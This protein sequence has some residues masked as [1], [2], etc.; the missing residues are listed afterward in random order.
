MPLLLLGAAGW[1]GLLLLLTATAGGEA[2]GARSAQIAPNYRSILGDPGMRWKPA[3]QQIAGVSSAAG[4]PPLWPLPQRSSNGS[5]ALRV[6]HDGSAGTFFSLAS[7]QPVATLVAAFYRYSQLTFPHHVNPAAVASGSF[8]GPTLHGLS[9]TVDDPSETVLQ[10]GTDESYSLDVRGDGTNATLHAATVYGAVR[11]LET[12]SQL[13]LFDFEQHA[14]TLPSAPW[15]ISDAPRFVHRGVMI[16][17]SRHFQPLTAVRRLIESMAYVKLN[18]LHWHMSDTQSFP[19]EVKSRP[20]LWK[21]AHSPQERYLQDDIAEVI[22]FARLRAV[23]VMVEFDLPGH[24]GS[25][26]R[27]Y[28]EVCPSPTCTPGRNR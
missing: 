10:L 21:A 11:G 1:L 3:A 26:C 14:Y 23:R 12:F 18:V 5:T 27:G 20:K 7:G 2:G 15:V 8:S 13:V 4:R 9:V 25:W 19:F 17:T 6:Q 16:D 22:E 28:P 24:A